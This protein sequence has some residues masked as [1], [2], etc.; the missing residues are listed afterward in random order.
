MEIAVKELTINRSN[1]SSTLY[2]PLPN[3]NAV[4]A[5]KT[6]AMAGYDHSGKISLMASVAPPRIPPAARRV[7]KVFRKKY[8]TNHETRFCRPGTFP[9]R[10]LNTLR[11]VDLLRM[12]KRANSLCTIVFDQHESNKNH[13]RPKPTTAPSEDVRTNSPEPTILP[14]TITPGPRC[15][16]RP[17]NDTGASVAIF[18]IWNSET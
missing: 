12:H 18:M 14:A 9:G 17:A 3:I 8:Q 2:E 16:S 11:N 6:N 4:R 7:M 13:K 1:L 10:R 15:R 5:V